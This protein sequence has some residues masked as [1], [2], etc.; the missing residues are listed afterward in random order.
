MF[1]RFY[2]VYAR[3]GAWDGWGGARTDHVTQR[4][5]CRVS[6][7]FQ[8]LLKIFPY[9]IKLLEQGA[10]GDKKQAGVSAQGDARN[11]DSTAAQTTNLLRTM[12]L[13]HMAGR[14]D[15]FPRSG[16]E[17]GNHVRTKPDK[18]S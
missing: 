1:A 17:S 14:A 10:A 9:Q 6:S 2:L 5:C 18:L 13:R 12:C 11:G 4:V 3:R 16:C 15:E 8:F 7:R